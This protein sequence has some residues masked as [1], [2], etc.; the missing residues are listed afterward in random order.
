[1]KHLPNHRLWRLLNLGGL[2]LVA[3]PLLAQTSTLA[4]LRSLYEQP[5]THWPP[6]WVDA[7]VAW[8]EL[9]PATLP[10]PAST[11]ERKRIALGARLFTDRQLSRDGTVAC[12]DCHQPEH[13][14][15]VPH[16]VGVGHVGQ[17]G[18]RNPPSLYGV[19]ARQHWGLDGRGTALATQSLVPLTDVQ[20]M[21]NPSL[22]AVLARVLVDADYT[23][24]LQRLDGASTMTAQL[25]GEL[26]TAFQ[27]S[28]DRPSRLDRFLQGEHKH[29]SDQEI[30]GLHLFRTKA[31]CINCHF[32]AQLSD[33]RFHNLGI[34]FFGEPSQDLGRYAVTGRC[35]DVGRFRTAS[36]RHISE[37]AP[38]MHNGLFSSLDGVIHLYTRGGGEVRAR[39]ATEAAHPLFPCAAQISAHI[40]PLPLT[41]TEIA[42][43]RAFLNSL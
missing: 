43:L 33:G 25:L 24:A 36:L 13:G 21:A 6:A 20:E 11:Q 35:E 8:A 14:W 37:T 40:R 41:T 5:T 1:M 2:L 42:A 15:T 34:S 29:L 38:Y 31:R 17:Q 32:G 10:P 39:N 18:Q 30:H 22:D 16:R 9:A 19:A 3:L 7:G 28:L 27:Q 26:M 4:D 23:A 12:V